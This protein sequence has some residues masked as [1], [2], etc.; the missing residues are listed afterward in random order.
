MGKKTGYKFG[1]ERF[2]CAIC[3]YQAKQKQDLIR[4]TKNIHQ[5]STTSKPVNCP[6]CN[7]SVKPSYLSEHRNLLHNPEQPILFCR[8]CT[9]QTK[10]KSN[11]TKHVENHFKNKS[12]H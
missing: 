10:K 11:F 7:K 1:M 2:P 3:S 12:I 9:F 5:P 6:D 4:H 8:F